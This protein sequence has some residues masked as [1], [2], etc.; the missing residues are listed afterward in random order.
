MTSFAGLASTFL[1]IE[2]YLESLEQCLQNKCEYYV[3]SWNLDTF[4]VLWFCNRN[5]LKV[6]SP[7]PLYTSL[8]TMMMATNNTPHDADVIGTTWQVHIINILHH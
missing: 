7:I 4:K 6:S 2:A 3:H 1:P 5:T 8:S